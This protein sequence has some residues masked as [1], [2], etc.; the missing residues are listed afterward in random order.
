MVRAKVGNILG[1]AM[2]GSVVLSTPAAAI[3]GFW[4]VRILGIW[5]GDQ[6][7]A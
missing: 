7:L 5:H 3:W 6:C 1:M 4:R 2:S